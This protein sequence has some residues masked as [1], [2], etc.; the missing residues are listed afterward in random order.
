MAQRKTKKS[1]EHK[2]NKGETE[3][4]V[5][6][7][8]LEG[9]DSMVNHSIL[10]I[11]D[12]LNDVI[13]MFNSRS[14]CIY[15]FILLND[16]LCPA[17]EEFIGTRFEFLEYIEKLSKD[18]HL[19]TKEKAVKL[20]STAKQLRHWFDEVALIEKTWMPSIDVECDLQ[21]KRRHIVKVCGNISKHHLGRLDDIASQVRRILKVS[22]AEISKMESF[23]A[24]D[25]IQEKFL[26]DVLTYR[27]TRIVTLLNTLRWDLHEYLW[28]CYLRAARRK[29]LDWDPTLIV[30]VYEYPKEIRDKFAR[31][32]F[33]EL[34][35]R[36]GR[37]PIFPRFIP[38]KYADE[39]F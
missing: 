39:K 5:L 7:L 37:G 26:D 30:T 33:W 22:G 27:A 35:Q 24:L 12:N 36:T 38:S 18:H 31:N 23:R 21:I 1:V 11:S 6:H 32:H 29:P 15:F 9:I 4:I 34:M 3:A 25:D 10:S 14:D 20:A 2:M 8:A 19:G 16:F 28:S 17:S 13:V